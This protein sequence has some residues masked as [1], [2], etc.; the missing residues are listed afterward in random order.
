MNG[1]DKKILTETLDIVIRLEERMKSIDEKL[2]MLPCHEHE[3]RMRTLEQWK[4]W[5]V[6][7]TAGIT[8]T[9]KLLWER[10]FK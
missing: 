3:K 6:G 4:Y 8:L 10:L 2:F 1:A 7:I 5:V 9:F